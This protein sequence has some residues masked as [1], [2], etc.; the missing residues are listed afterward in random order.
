MKWS[1]ELKRN[2]TTIKQ[3]EQ[4]IKLTPQKRSQL[5]K[6]IERH[7]MRITRYYMSLID[8]SDPHDPIM[9]MMVPSEEELTLSGSYDTSGEIVDTK[10]PGLQ[11]KYR[12]TVLLLATNRCASYCR[13]CFR[14]RLIG[15]PT[16]ELLRR[17]ST[18][19]KYVQRHTEVTNV[20]VS[21]GDAFILPTRIIEKFLASLVSVPH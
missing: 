9:K 7:P 16:E 19:V 3:L 18:A 20:L 6:I 11:H 8:R 12:Q 17:F 5:R 4:Y 1:N 14:K 10:M 2:I 13:Y 15:L 21:G